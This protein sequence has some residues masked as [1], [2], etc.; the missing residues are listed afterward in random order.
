[1]GIENG[2]SANLL[3]LQEGKDDLYGKWLGCLVSPT[4]G[5]S[6]EAIAGRWGITERTM[7]PMGFGSDPEFYEQIKYAFGGPLHVFKYEIR[8]D[9]KK[10]FTD[11]LE[12]AFAETR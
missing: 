6:C 4:V 11:M 2:V 1:L 9:V 7:F 5:V 12:T 10:L 8:D 3:L